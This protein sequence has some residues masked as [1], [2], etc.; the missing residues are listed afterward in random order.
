MTMDDNTR[1]V[2]ETAIAWGCL[3]A[4]VF[5]IALCSARCEEA[6]QRTEQIKLEAKK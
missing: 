5:A 6:G 1:D 3:V 2:I 4:C